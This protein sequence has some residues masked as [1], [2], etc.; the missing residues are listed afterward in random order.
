[1]QRSYI[2]QTIIAIVA[3]LIGYPYLGQ[4]FIL[5]MAPLVVYMVFKKD[6]AYLP[7]LMIHCS[8]ET[9][10]MY[11]VFFSMMIVCFI[12]ARVLISDKGTRWFFVFMI[13]SLP[14]YLLLTIQRYRLD[15]DTWQNALGYSSFYIAFWAFLYCYIVS[16][17]FNIIT[18][19]S[20]MISLL[21]FAVAIVLTGD[22]SKRIVFL[23]IIV[24]IIYGI[25]SLS[26]VSKKKWGVILG[27]M[28]IVF[29]FSYSGL[30][31]TLLLVLLYALAI[32]YLYKKQQKKI[33]KSITGIL[34]YFV[35]LIVIVNGITNYT[36]ASYGAYADSVDFS[37]MNKLWNRIQ[38]KLYGDRAPYWAAGWE[39]IISFAPIFPVHDIP[40]F[41]AYDA[42]GR[43]F[44]DVSFGAHN[45]PLQL[46][47]LF[48]FIMG[49]SLILCY[50]IS[51][52]SASKVFYSH[53]L[54]VFS[55]SLFSVSF[56]YLMVL[57]L[58][59]TASMLPDMA[60]FSFG[61]MGMAYG[62][63]KND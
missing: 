29:F 61:L 20:I 55:L 43:I 57:F 13:L 21:C 42:E 51:T 10:I 45:S 35:I 24:G 28:A 56:G 52:M 54:D 34:P 25:I 5:L 18:I 49:G 63:E 58:T 1:M 27:V 11:A 48:G 44:E 40:N 26:K 15:G 14:I 9:S 62:L 6:A 31:F 33:L 39:Q 19:K 30:T 17:T 41:T 23:A 59:G 32:V 4:M 2:I 8:S 50:M 37:D 46:L 53:K 7:A 16:N 36:T 47:R 3:V 22:L 38:Y 60:L 12:K